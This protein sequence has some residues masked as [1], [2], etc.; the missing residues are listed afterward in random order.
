MKHTLLYF[1]AGLLLC[2]GNTNPT[3]AQSAEPVQVHEIKTRKKT[4]A[5]DAE[6]GAS[7]QK[8]DTTVRKS[9]LR[10]GG[11]G[12][13]VMQRMFYSDH[14]ARYAY[15]ERHADVKHGR[16]D[17]PHVVFFAGYDFGRGWKMAAEGEFEHGGTG[18][19]VE[20]EMTEAGEYETEIEKGGEVVIEQFWIE[21]S[22][23]QALNLRL[24]HVIVPIGLT[25]MYHMP[26]EFFSVLRPE[27]E[28]VLIP[29]TWHETGISFWGEAK[30]WRYEAMFLAGL[31]AE[32]FSNAGWVSEGSV[33]PYEFKIANTY[34]GAFRVDNSTVK[35]LRMGLS[36]YF[37]YSASNRLKHDR[38]TD[39]KGAVS[40]GAFDAVYD[41]HNILAR[42]NILYGH[43]GDSEAISRINKRLPSAS[44]SPRTD[45]ASDA[46]SAYIEV[47]YDVLSFFP[48]RKIK[49]NR[50]Y[51]YGH[52]GYYNTML[53]TASA[54]IPVKGWCEKQI[55]SAGLNYYPMKGLVV[56]GEY[57]FRK[58]FKPEGSAQTPYNNEPA[59]SLGIG[60]SGLLNL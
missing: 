6:S 59:I 26:T 45:V 36:G 7:A 25:N 21:K 11:Y 33:S 29:C 40:I 49:T 19:A 9:R 27:E 20:I 24:G 46:F 32:R 35:G 58:F 5:T 56:K 15:P 52:Y 23:K 18:S 8:T 4:V 60:Y 38:Y 17:L 12:E 28:T 10:L 48:D 41:N 54:N 57:S 1:T 31:D 3:M 39:V 16:F 42:A 51:L 37:G 44:P 50:L 30:K 14:P 34:A 53:K 2:F 55:F 13:A 43:L 22:F 47:G